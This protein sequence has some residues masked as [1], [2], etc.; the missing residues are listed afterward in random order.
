VGWPGA[1]AGSADEQVVHGQGGPGGRQPG[2]ERVQVQPDLRR[3][4]V[5]QPQQRLG[6]DRHRV[7]RGGD[8]ELA[9]GVARV[10]RRRA[11]HGGVQVPQRLAH[12]RQQLLAEHRPPVPPPLALEQVVAVVPAQPGERGAH[13]R[14]AHP[15]PLAGPGQ[16]PVLE[17]RAQRQQQVEVNV[18]VFCQRPPPPLDRPATLPP[19]SGG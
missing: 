15:D 7:V 6:Q 17:E 18:D 16:V 3:D 10:E 8:G 2:R 19:T 4:P 12:G 9:V 13:R 11:L 14:L 5:N 1:K